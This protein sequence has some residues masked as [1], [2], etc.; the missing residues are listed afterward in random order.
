LQTAIQIG[1]TKPGEKPYATYE[2]ACA[3]AL[4]SA[5]IGERTSK[6]TAR[7]RSAKHYADQAIEALRQAV[8]EGWE[9]LTW[10]KADPDLDALRTRKDFQN[11]LESVDKKT[12]RE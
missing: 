7:D 2:L 9:N 11:V 10:M 3:Q 8:A 12:E 6:P 5:L 1:E 4:C